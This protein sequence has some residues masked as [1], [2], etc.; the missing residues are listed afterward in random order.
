MQWFCELARYRL[1]IAPFKRCRAAE[2]QL[3]RSVCPPLANSW[4]EDCECVFS[5]D[6]LFFSL[7]S[8]KTS[9]HCGSGILPSSEMPILP[10]RRR[11]VFRAKE[12]CWE[13]K[14]SKNKDGDSS[15]LPGLQRRQNDNMA[16]PE[17]QYAVLR[18]LEWQRALFRKCH[19]CYV[20][21]A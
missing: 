14:F 1:A 8:V 3:E 5:K 18:T 9:F 16:I 11:V 15:F 21:L 17:I 12:I 19:T 20:H 4:G 10:V 6:F 2:R 7:S 13:R